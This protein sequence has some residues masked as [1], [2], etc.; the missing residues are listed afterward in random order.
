MYLGPDVADPKMR[1]TNS[2]LACASCHP[3]AGAEPGSLSLATAINKYPQ[4][5]SRTG[6][7]ETIEQRINDCVTRSMN[8]RALPEDSSEIIA[9]VSYL[10]FLADKDAAT[11]ASMKQ[12]HDGPTFNQPGRDP[13]LEAG[14]HVFEKR[15]AACHGKDGAG[16][17]ASTNRAEGYIFPP[18]WGE[19]SFNEAAGLHRV[20]TAAEFIKAKMPA[21]KPDLDDSQAF[22]VAAYINSK[23][24]PMAAK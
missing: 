20:T 21:G 4:I 15:C 11:G 24:R 3:G 19:N 5:S 17:L 18:V 6:R 14:E 8:G 9:M 22:D 12:P 10:R 7:R 2:R 16:L 1:Y 23:P 13:D